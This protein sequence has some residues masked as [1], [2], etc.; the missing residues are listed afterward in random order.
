MSEEWLTCSKPSG[1]VSGRASRQPKSLHHSLDSRACT[2]SRKAK[3]FI[4]PCCLAPLIAFFPFLCI[5][6][7]RP[8][9]VN[10][11]IRDTSLDLSSSV[12]GASSSSLFFSF[13]NKPL[14]S[15]FPLFLCLSLLPSS[16]SFFVRLWLCSSGYL[17]LTNHLG[18]ASAS[19]ALGLQLCHHAWPGL[20][21]W[22]SF[23]SAA[24]FLALV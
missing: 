8:G 24:P 7:C 17:E 22:S 15:H 1:L 20:T 9:C 11:C 12:C 18:H 2:P 13:L 19:L 16:L 3:T 23:K 4:C 14:F 5:R 10:A 6:H 21:G